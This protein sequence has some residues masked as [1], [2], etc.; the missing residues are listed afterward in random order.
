MAKIALVLP[1]LIWVGMVQWG[2]ADTQG[3]L[4]LGRQVIAAFQGTDQIPWYT[5]FLSRQFFIFT[6]AGVVPALYLLCVLIGGSVVLLNRN[7][8]RH[9]V[10]VVWAFYGLLVHGANA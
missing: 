10:M 6:A 5:P 4:N 2:W 7:R 9:W 3:A 1:W 8:F